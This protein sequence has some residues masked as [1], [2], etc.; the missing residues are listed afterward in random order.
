MAAKF[1]F[2]N[3]D[4]KIA[5]LKAGQLER[6]VR[7]ARFRTMIISVLLSGLV[8]IAGILVIGLLFLRR[9]RN[10]VRAANVNLSLINTSLEKA[11]KAKTEFLATTSHEVRTPL[12]GILGMTQVILADPRV[13]PNMRERI[14]IVH[15]AAETMR[16]LVDDILD[17]A[18]I[19]NGSL[20]ISREEID[21]VRILEE[22]ARMWQ[23]KAKTKALDFKLNIEAAPRRIIEDGT[24]LRQVLFNLLSNAIKFTDV[25]EVSLTAKVVERNGVEHL[26]LSVSDTGIGIP[27]NQFEDVFTS[28][29]QLDGGTTRQH[30][31]TGLGLTICRN[32]VEAMSGKITVESGV[33]EGSVFTVVLPLTRVEETAEVEVT[34]AGQPGGASRL[35]ESRVLLVEANPLVQSMMKAALAPHVRTLEIVGSGALALTTLG[36]R[37]FDH[38]L[39]EGTAA[40]MPNMDCFRSIE[41]LIAAARQSPVSILWSEPTEYDRSILM[42]LGA[43]RVLAKPMSTQ[44]IVQNLQEF[45]SNP[46]GNGKLQPGIKS[47]LTT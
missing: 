27:S 18:K 24:R 47:L 34:D 46:P 6:D 41:I 36:Q 22:T 9:S 37:H 15:G 43:A 35:N 4:L 14:S 39:I 11:L 10:Q 12:N 42:A 29:K 17:V 38:I 3:Q 45:Y 8:I 2:A 23:E 44:A 40:H 20:S 25:G 21:L 33:R 5:Y 13:D 16:A 31:G 28:F 32:L 30:G 1:D 19:E 26:A 7:L